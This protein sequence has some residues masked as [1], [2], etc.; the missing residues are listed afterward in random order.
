MRESS[1]K[2]AVIVG[3]FISI[4]L[5]ILLAGVLM[6]GN[7]HETFSTKVTVTTFFDDVN[8]LQT[9]NNIWFSG[10]KVG[11]VKAIRFHS[12]LAVEVTMMVNVK[13]QEYIRKDA[14]VK[15][16]TDGLIGNKILVIY[17]GT[18][19]FGPIEN[20]DTLKVEKAVSQEDM[21]KILQ[22]SNK[23]IMSITTDFKVISKKLAA[24]EGTIG[25]LLSDNTMYDEVKNAI[26][27]IQQT[28]L[29]GQQ[30]LNNL[31]TYTAKLNQ[32]GALANDLVTDTIVFNSIR[33]F[34]LRLNQIADTTELVVRHLKKVSSD[35]T[36]SVG[37]LLHDSVEGA[38]LKVIL[39]NLESSSKKLDEDLE[40]AQ[41]S[42]LLKKGMKKK[43]KGK[44]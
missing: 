26:R 4:G 38:R 44:K 33:K 32:E 29:K 24:G 2:R 1:N 18:E 41:S 30:V 31:N 17:G 11:T 23:N 19:K 39:K 15:L 35:T 42:F 37:I 25:K 9:G 40:A 22:E 27:S 20:G 3:L 36:T 8:G 10:V 6:V 12:Q 7:L 16:S 34:S 28:S 5:A 13:T 21:L 43:E 14:K